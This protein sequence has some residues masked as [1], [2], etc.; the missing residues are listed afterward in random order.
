MGSDKSIL[1]NE[2][3]LSL[4]PL[5]DQQFILTKTT[6][7]ILRKEYYLNLCKENPGGDCFFKTRR[8]SEVTW[9]AGIDLLRQ[10]NIFA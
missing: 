4:F 3:T 1:S 9:S 2:Q 8:A 7:R 5:S 10:D 6:S